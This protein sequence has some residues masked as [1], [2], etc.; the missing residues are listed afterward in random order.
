MEKCFKLYKSIYFFTITIVLLDC[1]PFFK[2]YLTFQI[3]VGFEPT[4]DE[5][6]RRKNCDR[7][8]RRRDTCILSF[9]LAH[10]NVLLSSLC[11]RS[12]LH[13]MVCGEIWGNI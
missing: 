12:R 6:T 5:V 9:F 1:S 10:A 8:L 2:A 7:Q 3:D 11:D 13:E 4:T